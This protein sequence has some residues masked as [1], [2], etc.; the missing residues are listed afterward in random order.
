MNDLL[1]TSFGS[2]EG[3]M[4]VLFIGHGSPMNAIEKNEYTDNWSEL[5][6][7]LPKPKA[8]LSISAHWLTGGT[9]VT[10][11]SEPATIH[12]FGG[13]PDELFDIKY[14]AAG[15]PEYAE[16]TRQL[17][18]PSLIEND[19]K[20]GL[21]H[22][23]W[24]VLLPMFPKAEIPVFQMSID[25]SKP[26]SFHYDLAKQIGAL[27]EHGILIMGSGNIVHNLS[28]LKLNREPYD[29]AIE[30]DKKVTGFI[31]SG[32]DNAIVNFQNM[33]SI[34][35][36]SQPTYDHFLPLIYILGLKD[37][38]DKIEIFNSGFDLGSIS[39]KSVIF[40]Q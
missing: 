12:D 35:R 5:G 25:Y 32:N 14:P 13:F 1:S 33:G 31:E 36:M 24:S 39:M 2:M 28:T 11:T 7:L 4:P 37:K 20:W 19:Y 23:T 6:K 40:Y 17:A 22:G 30:F 10:A 29:W 27:R 9:Y 16:K 18:A 8:I 26:P 3:K 34:S 38:K 15:S 21:D